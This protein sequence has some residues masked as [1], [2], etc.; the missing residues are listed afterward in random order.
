[1]TKYKHLIKEQRDTIQYM[2]DNNHSFSDIA[3][4]IN[5]DRTTI[6]KE[7]RR[8]SYIKS[9]CYDSFDFSNKSKIIANCKFL[10]KPPYVCN[11]CYKKKGCSKHKIYYHSN[12]AQ[13]IYDKNKIDARSGYDIDQETID[14]IEQTIVPLIKNKKQSINQVYAS[15]SD[16]LF[17][18]KP[19]F[20]KYINLGILSLA[21]INLPKKVKYK[22]RKKKLD[23]SFK[24]KFIILNK[25]SYDDYLQF[26]I[27][28]PSFNRCQMDTVEGS[29]SSKKVLLTIILLDT[30]FMLIRL[31]PNKSAKSV[32]NEFN[33]IKSSLGP[34]L[35]SRVFRI[36][37]T[38]NGPEFF[39]PLDIELNTDTGEKIANVFFCNPYSSWQK[40]AIEKN[41]EFIRRVFPKGTSFSNISPAIIKKL[42][43][44]INNIPRASLNNLSPFQ[45]T[46]QKYPEF[47][48][49]LSCSFIQP[50]DVSL[51]IDNFS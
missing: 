38:D 35:F 12:I 48:S 24:R 30:K 8:N 28:N 11:T 16:I 27:D 26:V 51:D 46:F 6:S 15:H 20:Y 45:L 42:E 2:I 41:H 19:T 4:A 10:S 29:K 13:Q 39:S 22:P 43:D 25:R 47:I 31:L 18:S 44:N 23:T 5:K 49:N 17:F 36:I 21:N 14:L 33:I 7:I 9:Y 1:M 3:K 50:D 40:C 34:A 32:S 37:L